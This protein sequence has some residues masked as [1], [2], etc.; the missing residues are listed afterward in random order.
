MG[1][2]VVTNYLLIFQQGNR[3]GEENR[4][5][6]EGWWKNVREGKETGVENGRIDHT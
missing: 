4:R 1:V 3:N 2:L 5:E 6:E